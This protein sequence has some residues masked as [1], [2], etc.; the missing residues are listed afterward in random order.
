MTAKY[1]PAELLDELDRISREADG[2][3]WLA[4]VEGRDQLGG[5]SFIQVGDDGNRLTDIYVTRDRTPALAAE[6][7]V[8]AAA[9]TY[10]PQLL[11][12]IRE[13]RRRLAQFEA[14]DAR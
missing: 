7:D 9:R 3:P 1:L 13:L 8:I 11:D 10:L 4:I 6:L 12:E 5:D 14:G 2:P